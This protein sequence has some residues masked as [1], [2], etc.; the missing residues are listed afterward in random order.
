MLTVVLVLFSS[1]SEA[2]K[3]KPGGVCGLTCYRK[4]VVWKGIVANFLLYFQV[5]EV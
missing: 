2:R 1:S 5:E 4:V 3:R